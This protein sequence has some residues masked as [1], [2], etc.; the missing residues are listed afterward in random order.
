MVAVAGQ[1]RATAKFS[2]TS[3]PILTKDL[4]SGAQRA[5]VLVISRQF[6]ALGPRSTIS[7]ILSEALECRAF[8]SCSS[9]LAQPDQNT[10]VLY[11]KPTVCTSKLRVGWRSFSRRVSCGAEPR[12]E[13][14]CFQAS[15]FGAEASGVCAFSVSRSLCVGREDKMLQ[16]ARVSNWGSPQDTN[17]TTSCRSIPMC[18]ESSSGPVTIFVNGSLGANIPPIDTEFAFKGLDIRV[19]VAPGVG[20][21][22]GSSGDYLGQAEK[23]ASQHQQI[24]F[25]QGWGA[26]AVLRSDSL[27]AECAEDAIVRNLFEALAQ[28]TQV[29][30]HHAT[31]QADALR[32]AIAIRLLGLNSAA[33]QSAGRGAQFEECSDRQVRSLQKW[34]LKRVVDYID[35]HLSER[36]TLTDLASVAGLSRMHFASQFRMATGLRPHEFL[37]RRRIRKAEE[38][39][40]GSSMQI[41]QIALA[42]GFQS[43]AHFTTVFKRFVGYTPNQWRGAHRAACQA[44]STLES[45]MES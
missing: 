41:I 10:K 23:K 3:S 15:L 40:F 5:S 14:E 24:S 35:D 21:G 37:L 20:I 19:A 31:V 9:R 43:Q 1:P 42:V 22:D 13:E 17:R 6:P 44:S 33:R 38:L 27:M 34:R 11:R 26:G 32:L 29:H 16:S 25:L 2:I 7:G 36:I 45:P 28:V 4:L 30:H 12:H 39:L 18:E 8:S